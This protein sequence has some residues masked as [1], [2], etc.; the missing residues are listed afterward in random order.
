MGDESEDRVGGQTNPGDAVERD[1]WWHPWN[2]EAMMEETEGLAYD[3]PRSDSNAMIMGAEGSQGP[4]LYL[5]DKA[6]DSPPNTLRNSASHMLGSPMEHM[7]LLGAAVTD[8]NA[9][10]VHVDEEEL[11]NL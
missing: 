7:P 2:W 6:T 9:V 10:E 4:E 3:D 1:Q 5:Y 11:N 8:G